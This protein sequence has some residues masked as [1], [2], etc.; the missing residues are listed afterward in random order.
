MAEALGFR[1][2][3]VLSAAQPALQFSLQDVLLQCC[4]ARP[5]PRH[6]R[7]AVKRGHADGHCRWSWSGTGPSRRPSANGLLSGTWLPSGRPTAGGEAAP[8]LALCGS[9]A[10]GAAMILHWR[11]L[12]VVVQA[13][14]K[15]PIFLCHWRNRI[16]YSK[17][18]ICISVSAGA[19]GSF[20]VLAW[21]LLGFTRGTRKLH[22]IFSGST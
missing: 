13:E 7:S 3:R 11:E 2:E 12:R 10:C 6:H 17:C 16:R 1:F 4:Q 22:L 5:R 8:P 19:V 21:G 14:F 20:R 15:S 9:I 18:R